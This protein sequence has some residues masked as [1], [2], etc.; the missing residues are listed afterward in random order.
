MIVDFTHG[1]Y[2]QSALHCVYFFLAIWGVLEW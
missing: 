2:A 1:I